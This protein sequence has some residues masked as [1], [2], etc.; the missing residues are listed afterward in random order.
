MILK[1]YYTFQRSVEFPHRTFHGALCNKVCH[2][3]ISQSGLIQC[4]NMWYWLK[5]SFEREGNGKEMIPRSDI[6]G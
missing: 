4:K 6:H 5:N 1:H 3:S 2:C